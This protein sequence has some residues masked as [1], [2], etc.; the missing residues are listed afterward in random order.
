VRAFSNPSSHG[1]DIDPEEF[2]DTSWKFLA[3]L[4]ADYY[5]SHVYVHL[6][7]SSSKYSTYKKAVQ[8]RL[9][10]PAKS[11][12]SKPEMHASGEESFQGRS[13]VADHLPRSDT[14][15]AMIRFS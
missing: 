3:F 13:A 5:T 14:S 1:V 15:T 9:L 7:D 4:R 10:L 2:C 11:S 8:D 12:L 6:D